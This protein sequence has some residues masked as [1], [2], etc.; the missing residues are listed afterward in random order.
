MAGITFQRSLELLEAA[1]RVI[2]RIPMMTKNFGSHL[3]LI[4]S[5]LKISLNIRI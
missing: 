5:A 4:G 1:F 3:N 2:P